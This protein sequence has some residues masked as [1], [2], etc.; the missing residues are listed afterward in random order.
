MQKGCMHDCIIVCGKINNHAPIIIPDSFD[1]ELSVVM[2]SV[3][4]MTLTCVCAWKI[5][6]QTIRLLIMLI[7][8]SS[9]QSEIS[10][11]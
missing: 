8:F 7:I 10:S 5:I 3:I 9:R 11:T 2:I 4:Y 1:V 6:K